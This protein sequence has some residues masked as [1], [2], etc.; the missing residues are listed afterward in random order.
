MQGS[1]Q[2]A[3]PPPPRAV[4]RRG[5][6]R[7]WGDRR[8]RVWLICALAIAAIMIFIG[9]NQIG[10]ALRERQLIREGTVLTTT[11]VELEGSRRYGYSLPRTDMRDVKLQAKLP[12]GTERDFIGRLPPGG[13]GYWRVGQEMQ[14]RF[15]PNDPT[16]WTNR[17]EMAGWGTELVIPLSLVPIIALLL[18]LAIWQ[19][20]RVLRIWRNGQPVQGVV[21]E[22]RH[23]AIAPLSRV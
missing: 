11:L 16:R 21:H 20:M 10:A 13:D 1:E 7:A 4:T 14:I 9:I 6:W 8:V 19:R 12:D 2:P 23:T 18:A 5:W 15:D 22:L 17:T 3:L